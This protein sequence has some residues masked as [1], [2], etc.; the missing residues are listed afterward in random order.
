[1]PLP[2]ETVNICEPYPSIAMY[3]CMWRTIS[4]V[5]TGLYREVAALQRYLDRC[6][7]VLTGLYREVAALQR[8]LDRCSTV[9]TGLY[10]EVAALQRY[11]DRC[12]AV[13]VLLGFREA[14]G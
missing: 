11:L 1:M 10:R 3:V 6:S 8:Y 5:L 9:L 2:A 14:G 13:L 4:T 7:A 12:S